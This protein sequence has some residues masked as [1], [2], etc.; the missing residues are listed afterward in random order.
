[1][2]AN[3]L[4]RM[5]DKIWVKSKS[6]TKDLPTT[7]YAALN[8]TSMSTPGYDSGD[9]PSYANIA[10]Y[11][12]FIDKE[13]METWVISQAMPKFGSPNSNYIILESKVLPIKIESK[14]NITGA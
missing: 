10:E 8:F 6:D 11:I 13:A 5:R 3:Q 4:R 1:M 12:A 9:P 14:V 7:H 2:D